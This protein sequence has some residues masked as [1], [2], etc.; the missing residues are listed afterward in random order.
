MVGERCAALAALPD[1][2]LEAQVRAWRV[3]TRQRLA[4][5]LEA[6]LARHPEADARW[7]E[8]ATRVAA[9]N[10]DADR[11]ERIDPAELACH[12]SALAQVAA[13]APHWP[14]LWKRM[15]DGRAEFDALLG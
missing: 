4:G 15:R 8:I 11:T 14:Q 1:T 2:T 13:V 9:C 7:R 10:R 5:H 12:R 3:Q 6:A